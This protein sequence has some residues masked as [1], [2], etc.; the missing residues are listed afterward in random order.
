MPEVLILIQ[1]NIRWCYTA[2]II[3]LI[4]WYKG[5]TIDAQK[6]LKWLAVQCED[7]MNHN[8]FYMLFI[9]FY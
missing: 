2:Q 1:K 8:C 7:N 4:C 9:V 3:S 6:I 5:K